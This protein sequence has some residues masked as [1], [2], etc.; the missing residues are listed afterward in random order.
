MNKL[1]SVTVWPHESQYQHKGATR[2]MWLCLAGGQ[3]LF[4]GCTVLEQFTLLT[5]LHNFR[6]NKIYL[7]RELG[8]ETANWTSWIFLSGMF[9]FRK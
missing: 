5:K 4:T 1:V 8:I 7:P 2:S 3:R 6:I 9:L